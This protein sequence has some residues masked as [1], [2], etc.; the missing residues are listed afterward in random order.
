MGTIERSF[1]AALGDF[2]LK[3]SMVFAGGFDA[4]PWRTLGKR[5][6]WDRPGLDV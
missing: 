2:M 1:V 6:K 5:T 4:V 3:E